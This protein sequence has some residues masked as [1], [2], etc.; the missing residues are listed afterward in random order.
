MISLDQKQLFSVITIFIVVIV[1]TLGFSTYFYLLMSP[2]NR[3]DT[4]I[5]GD[6]LFE[7]DKEVGFIASKNSS[8]HIV[9]INKGQDYYVYTDK[10]GAR[11]NHSNFESPEKV[12]ILGIGGS[13]TWGHGIQNENSFLEVLGNGLDVS[14]TNFALASYGTLQSLQLLER[15]IHLNP[16]VIIYGFI[17][18][19]IKRNLKACAPSISPFCR[20][21]SYVDF[22]K[23]DNPYIHPPKGEYSKIFYERFHEDVIHNPSI[24]GNI[25]WGM[26]L[27][28]YKLM[29]EKI[30][31][32]LKDD[33]HKRKSLIYLVNRMYHAAKKINAAL[34]ILFIPPLER[35]AK[36]QPPQE[37]LQ[38]LNKDIIFI[39]LGDIINQYYRDPTKPLLRFKK[40]GHPNEL[41]HKIMADEIKKVL[42]IKKIF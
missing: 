13:F 36:R 2:L 37:L 10:Q 11:R 31:S 4:R 30:F 39:N 14:V 40:D 35:E 38:S 32:Y 9:H 1:I 27:F 16:K 18:D 41:A 15:N 42:K 3:I 12:D 34:I 26:K 22:D 6:L 21:V 17:S 7:G 5:E 25:S 19:H 20:Y 33:I 28:T 24:F 8:S 29:G 23:Q